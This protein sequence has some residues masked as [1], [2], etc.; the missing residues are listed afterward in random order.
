MEQVISLKDI[1]IITVN[2]SLNLL[3]NALK[4]QN[5]NVDEMPSEYY[6]HDL[7][8]R[9]GHIAF[10]NGLY[11][12]ATGNGQLNN[13]GKPSRYSLFGKT[14][15]VATVSSKDVKIL[16][17]TPKMTPI[18]HDIKVLS[19]QFA[20]AKFNMMINIQASSNPPIWLAENKLIAQTYEKMLKQKESGKP[21]I[22]TLKEYV[23]DKLKV[24][25]AHAEFIADKYQQLADEI[26]NELLT[27]LGI[28]T[29]NSDKR[30]RVQ[31]AEIFA[32]VGES[33]D[34]I[35]MI[36]DTFNRDAE[37]HNLEIRLFNDSTA[38]KMIDDILSE[39]GEEHEQ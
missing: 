36:T 16:R 19:Y 8:F 23:N 21:I 11:L 29:A 9:E 34:Y 10:W 13:Y 7:L 27:K 17:A 15:Q 24:E 37:R 6:L 35:K 25:D 20:L 30:E 1:Y 26:K 39:E 5:V 4:F 38:V 22:I 14:R 3:S 12:K 28:V 31:Q 18:I 2:E 32:T 33:Y